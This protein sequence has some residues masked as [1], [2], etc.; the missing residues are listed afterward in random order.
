[1]TLR[2]I[3]L[4]LLY[5]FFSFANWQ[6]VSP[7]GQIR[8]NVQL[9]PSGEARYTIQGLNNGNW[10]SVLNESKLGVWRSDE[11]FNSGLS[12]VSISSQTINETYSM[13]TGKQA[14]LQNHANEIT[15]NFIKGTNPL[16]IIFRAYDE[17]V[18]F[19]YVFTNTSVNEY[20]M[21]YDWT[22]FNVPI[23]GKMWVQE[24]TN[25]KPVYE[26]N[27]SEYNV[28]ANTNDGW[29]FPALMQSGNFYV[30]LSE[31]D[32]KNTF[33][34]THL[35]NYGGGA[36]YATLMPSNDDGSGYSGHTRIT[37]PLTMPWKTIGISKNLA[38][39]VES[40]LVHHVAQPSIITNTSWIKP[41]VSTWGWWSDFFNAKSY[42]KLQKFVDL[43]DSLNVPYSLVDVDWNLMTGGDLATLAQYAA[44]KNV[45]LWAWYNSAGPHNRIDAQPRD[46][47]FDRTT[48]RNEM[49]WLKSIGIVGV[50]VDF[51]ESDKK[52]LIK[53]YLDILEDAA[54]Y[55]LMVNFHG[56]TIPRGWQRTYPHLVTVE[57]VKGDEALLFNEPFRL[58]S[59]PHNVN[60]A[61]TRN[62][63]GSMDYTPGVLGEE[64]VPHNTTSAHEYAL[65]SLFESG[66]VHLADSSGNYFNL[67]ETARKLLSMPTAWDET[68]FVEGQPND[69]VVLARRKGEDWYISGINGKNTPRSITLNPSFLQQA[70]YQKQTVLDGATARQITSTSEV[71]N[72]TNPISINMLPYGGFTVALKLSCLNNLLITSTLSQTNPPFKAQN[73]EANNVIQSGANIIYSANKSVLLNAG[74]NAQ[75]GSVFKAE[76]GGCEN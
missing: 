1:M 23:G 33:V 71:Y 38:G 12:F 75:S 39:I 25:F 61:F 51:F 76:I 72:P 3:S 17:G 8:A 56:A 45:K 13:L 44:T 9:S 19:R 70:I 69:Y 46:K 68:R 67:P 49:Q 73:I 53:L 15:L 22:T 28:G 2:I 27:V 54:D 60:L 37:L 18:A 63:I 55:Q 16:Q 5:P 26:R 59:P 24:Y 32:L 58:S 52:Q 20:E 48:R 41:G 74:F 29:C 36:G 21:Y 35:G 14:N 62:V 65:I 42:T 40:N 30:L 66:V 47:M 4:I 6:V 11:N 64:R 7:N 57:A 10:V 31:S 50:K 34:G 43:A